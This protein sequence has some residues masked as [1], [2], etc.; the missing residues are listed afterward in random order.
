MNFHAQR[1]HTVTRT[2]VK[3]LQRRGYTMPA[4]VEARTQ[5]DVEAMY[6]AS[7]APC[8][9]FTAHRSGTPLMVMFL[10]DEHASKLG[11]A[12]IRDLVTDMASKHCAEALLVV[13]DGLTAPAASMVRELETKSSVT[14][15][16]FLADTLLYDIWEHAAVPRHTLLTPAEKDDLLRSLKC[17]ADQLPRIMRDDPMARYMGL[18][19][20]DVVRID[21]PS[22]TVGMDVYYRVVVESEE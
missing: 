15:T 11:L 3:M 7:S 8:L 9:N 1:Q 19:V 6:A 20:G 18:R 21:R 14:L 17:T 5:A 4:E 10:N 2:L 12:P 13:H 22:V 16:T